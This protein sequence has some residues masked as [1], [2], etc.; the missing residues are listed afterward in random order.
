MV[1][2]NH[3]GYRSSHRGAAEMNPTRNHQV[4]GSIPGLFSGLRT[5]CCHV[6]CGVGRSHGSDLA[7]RWLWCRLA[8]IAPI[9]CRAW[10]PPYAVGAALKGQRTNKNYGGCKRE[11]LTV[12]SNCGL[13]EYIIIFL[14]FPGK[15]YLC[16]LHHLQYVENNFQ[17]S[18][19]SLPLKFKLRI[20]RSTL[21]RSI[22]NNRRWFFKQPDTYHF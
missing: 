11:C 6:S 15:C 5:Q 7:W 17:A 13:C 3:S 21:K 18:K 16:R 14:V 10:E 12:L 1:V 2:V 8:A 19:G 22:C 20:K 9:R 4:A